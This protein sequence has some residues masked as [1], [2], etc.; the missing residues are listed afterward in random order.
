[1]E[2]EEYK[3]QYKQQYV[4]EAAAAI[5]E[6]I[7]TAQTEVNATIAEVYTSE[8]YVELEQTQKEYNVNIYDFT[9]IKI[10]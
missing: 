3:A 8:A 4:D 6:A 7:L 2:K 10:P 9:G 1:M 5:D